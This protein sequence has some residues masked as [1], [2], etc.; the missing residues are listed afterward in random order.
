MIIY[1]TPTA[2]D[3][4]VL[5]S[6]ERAIFTIDPWS[7]GQFKEEIAGIGKNRFYMVAESDGQ[8]VGWGGA[9]HIES[10]A[11][12][13]VFTLAVITE[14]RGQGIARTILREIMAW[15][16]SKQVTTMTLEAR[17]KNAEAI[18]LY[19]SE[20]F[21]TIAERRDYYAPGVDAVVMKREMS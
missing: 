18:A 2:L 1:R 3:I 6:H 10:A 11:E 7:S 17:L 14:F 15:S 21:T 19:E 13:Q 20:G 16:E 5:V 8:I 12:V 4:P 9:M